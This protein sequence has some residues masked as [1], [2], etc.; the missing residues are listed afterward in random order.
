MILLKCNE[1]IQAVL[2]LSNQIGVLPDIYA[3]LFFLQQV[4]DSYG[5]SIILHRPCLNTL[6]DP[7]P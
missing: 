3:M 1:I 7:P 5:T 2:V 4:L 6:C